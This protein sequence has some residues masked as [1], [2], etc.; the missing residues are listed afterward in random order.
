MNLVIREFPTH[1]LLSL[2]H[3]PEHRYPAQDQQSQKAFCH[4]PFY[5]CSLPNVF[6]VT[7]AT[8]LIPFC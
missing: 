4:P 1:Q 5:F 6:F 3:L 7:I 8:T 2:N